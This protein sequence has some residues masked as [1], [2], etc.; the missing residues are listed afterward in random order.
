MLTI[1]ERFPR[2]RQILPVYAVIAFIVYAWTLLWFF[3]KLPG[4]MFFLGIGNI[5]SALAYALVVNLAESLLVLGAV[6]GLAWVLPSRW[7]RD[8][9]VARGAAL[10]IAGL[11]Y[12][13][14]LADRFKDKMS[15]P[16]LPLAAWTVPAALAALALVVYL[17]GRFGV[18]RKALEGIADSATIFLYILVPASLL[19]L[20]VILF[21]SLSR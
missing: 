18:V 14:F 2:W 7:F 19:S 16:A 10:C 11:G 9:F 8:V 4:W 5:V 13:M 20:I 12:L 6:L 15:Y 1:L 17:C 3:W 21:N